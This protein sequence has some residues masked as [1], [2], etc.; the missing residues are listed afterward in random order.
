MRVVPPPVPPVF[1]LDKSKTPMNSTLFHLFHLIHTIGLSWLALRKA[2]VLG[3]DFY[4]GSLILYFRWN[5]W[6]RLVFVDF[7]AILQVEP[8]WNT[9]GS[10][11]TGLQTH[12]T[13]FS[14]A[15][16]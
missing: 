8:W 7:L 12:T 13:A 11:G 9:G 4:P 10:G 16:Q 5:R 1:H 2:V 6:N 14:T 15:S 3:E